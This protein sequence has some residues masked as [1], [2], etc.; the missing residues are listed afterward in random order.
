M[1]NNTNK[2]VAVPANTHALSTNDDNQTT[3]KQSNI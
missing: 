2:H 1:H 3:I